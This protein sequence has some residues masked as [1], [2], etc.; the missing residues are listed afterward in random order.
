MEQGESLGHYTIVGHLGR[1]G[2]GEVFAALDATL[3]R[4]V[5]LKVLPPHLAGA[6]ERL[7]RFRREAQAVAALNHPNIVTIHSVEEAGGVHFITLELIEGRSL[8]ALIPSDGMPIGEFFKVAI[9]LV[10]AVAAAHGRGIVHRDLKP[11]NVMVTAEGRVKVLDFGLAK[12]LE[13]S[14][15]NDASTAMADQH[16]TGEG[17]VMGT[18]AYMSPEQAEARPLDHRTDLF[19]LG[20][21]L[22]QMTTGELPFKGDT[23]LSLMSA[24][25]RDT[26][27]SIAEINDRL[28]RHLA[29]IV[30]KALEKD[31]N[32]R[33]QTALDLRNDLEE[34]KQELD[35]RDP[36]VTGEGMAPVS[37]PSTRRG[38]GVP[39]AVAGTAVVLAAL[40]WFVGRPAPDTSQEVSSFTLAALTSGSGSDMAPSISPDGGLVVFQR[41]E[42]DRS[43]IFLQGVGDRRA[44][45]LTSDLGPVGAPA[46][47]PDGSQIA[48]HVNARPGGI[49]LMGRTGGNLRRLTD[50]GFDPAWSP[51]GRRIVF[52]LERVHAGSPYVRNFPN[53]QLVIADVGTGE[54]TETGISDAVQPS[55]SPDGR[56]F[57]YWGFNADGLRDVH[58]APVDGG[59]PLAVTSDEFFDFS[60]VWSPDG[61]W[62]YFASTRGGSMAIWRVPF[63]EIDGAVGGEPQQVTSGGAADAGRLSFSS[64]GRRLVYQQL[65]RQTTVEVA[66]FDLDS[67]TV[68]RERT[69]LLAGARVLTAFDVS[70]DGE[71]IAYKN[72]GARSDIYVMRSDGSDERQLTDDA[73]V[74]FYPRW[75]PD[76]TRLTFYSNLEGGYQVWAIGRDGGNRIRLSDAEVGV[77]DPVWSPDGAEIIY[78]DR[79]PPETSVIVRSDARFDQQEPRRLPRFEA[80]G[81]TIGFFPQD[82]SAVSGRIAG[83]AGTVY[84]PS[85]GTFDAPSARRGNRTRWLPDGRRM[86]ILASMSVFD[87]ATDSVRPIQVPE[88]YQMRLWPD[89]RH[90]VLWRYSNQSHIW[91]LDFGG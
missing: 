89:G 15:T 49:W 18:V 63:D 37:A 9:P 80:F 64:D 5:A 73:A 74:D 45:Q 7:E 41:V 38:W 25:V 4:R 35:T 82:W 28:P 32:R 71:W 62:L 56:W 54:E 58:I 60:P 50:R 59:A 67:L 76:A 83:S 27:S 19:S 70:L 85:T 66:D 90:A 91:L 86:V 68:G 44:V 13:T 3:N 77:F 40:W 84:D 29:R 61:A 34:L 75:S 20:I 2:M 12:L 30:R 88:G 26:P 51:D 72:V 6:P 81:N 55:W 69:A 57:A 43:D 10:D 17:R 1:G 8:D 24:I 33:Y 65:V 11:G 79:T 78:F 42:G 23:Q 14:S 16:L 22:Y 31:V 39:A 36:L 47:S 53:Q 87:P 48:F 52:G 46:F 21:L